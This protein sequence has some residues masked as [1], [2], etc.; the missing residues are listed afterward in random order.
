MGHRKRVG[1]LVVAVTLVLCASAEKA[2]AQVPAGTESV[3]EWLSVPP[4]PI[5]L[6]PQAL[7]EAR[8][9]RQ[10]PAPGQWRLLYWAGPPAMI[11]NLIQESIALAGLGPQDCWGMQRAWVS[12]EGRWFG[13]D[14]V[15]PEGSDRWEVQPGEA[16]FLYR[17]GLEGPGQPQIVFVRPQVTA[18]TPHMQGKCFWGSRYT[19]RADAAECVW[20]VWGPYRVCPEGRTLVS[21]CTKQVGWHLGGGSRTCYL[22]PPDAV[23]AVCAESPFSNRASAVVEL[24]DPPEDAFL[25]RSDHEVLHPWAIELDDGTRCQFV[26]GVT[27]HAREAG[28]TDWPGGFRLSY[29]CTTGQFPS[30]VW[31]V[32][33]PLVYPDGSW[34]ILNVVLGD[35]VPGT[36]NVFNALQIALVRIRTVW[37]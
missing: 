10:C 20:E 23:Q 7:A 25:R 26:A 24:V 22:T 27:G 33:S 11:S 32:G 36:V 18:S 17:P 2:A 15:N 14:A 31:L 3:R 19:G 28:E 6:D 8:K 1:W 21:E 13:Y 9:Q 16:H 5:R 35:L 29:T 4:P 30:E 12:R 37:L 34:R